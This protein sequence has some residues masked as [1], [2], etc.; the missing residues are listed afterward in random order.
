MDL[1]WSGCNDNVAYGSAMARVFIDAR[2]KVRGKFAT[3]A[4][5]NL[6]NN[7]AG[8]KVCWLAGGGMA[9]VFLTF[10]LLKTQ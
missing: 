7:N 2:E 8:R 1:K 6:H 10:Y 4:L 5:I 9:I 3:R